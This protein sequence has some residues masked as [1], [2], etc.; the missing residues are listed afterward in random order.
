MSRP[1]EYTPARR[2]LLQVVMGIILLGT[3]ALAALV[4][5]VN[6]RASRV[7]LAPNAISS[8]DIKVR[9]PAGWR[10]LPSTDE[11]HTVVQAEELTGSS[12]AG[13]RLAVMFES[14]QA[15]ASPVQYLVERFR[16]RI[17]SLDEE[18]A[19]I[20]RVEAAT[21][22]GQEGV[23]VS[24]DSLL[25]GEG[26]P[27][28]PHK[29]VFAAAV[30]PSRRVVVVHLRGFGQLDLTDRAVVRHVAAAITVKDEPAI[31]PEGKAAVAL[32]SGTRF[33]P[34][35]GF[36]AVESRDSLRTDRL[37]WPVIPKPASVERRE[38]LWTTIEVV[39]C[40]FSPSADAS[41]AEAALRTLLLVRDPAWRNANITADAHNRWS[42]KPPSRSDGGPYRTRAYLRSDASGRALLAIC[43]GGFGAGAGFEAAWEELEKS[44][45]FAPA[46]PFDAME[47]EGAAIASRLRESGYDRTITDRTEQWWLW[48]DASERPHVGW[49]HLEFDAAGS[50]VGE[51][52]ARS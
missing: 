31:A 47:S 11:P 6:R 15:P 49:S 13:R 52:Q 42:A 24:I 43:R 38:A 3:I 27:Q 46:A 7:E 20:V 33:T 36:S 22:A 34:P 23:L 14:L 48:T 18:Q 32:P 29:E 8:G 35:V 10:S 1:S 2:R 4:G 39:E 44:I 40:H 28:L 21:V 19:P 51:V 37:L 41:S 17:T 12:G 26:T 16:L 5:S 45:Q 50:A 9:P 25:L 30:L